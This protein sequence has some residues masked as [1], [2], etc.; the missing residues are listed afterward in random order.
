MTPTA[1]RSK[2]FPPK[3]KATAAFETPSPVS[4]KQDA[5]NQKSDALDL[6]ESSPEKAQSL[7]VQTPTPKKATKKKAKTAKTKTPEENKKQEDKKKKK[8][9]PYVKEC[10]NMTWFV[11]CYPSMSKPRRVEFISKLFTN[12]QQCSTYFNLHSVHGLPSIFVDILYI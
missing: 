7:T 5:K 11:R 2:P 10:K 12:V 1:K 3:Q 4:E 9:Q 6:V 8:T